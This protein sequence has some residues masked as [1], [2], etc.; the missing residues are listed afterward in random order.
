VSRRRYRVATI[1][2]PYQPFT[3]RDCPTLSWSPRIIERMKWKTHCVSKSLTK[4]QKSKWI[5]SVC[6]RQQTS[7]LTTRTVGNEYIEVASIKY[8]A[9]GIFLACYCS[10]AVA[11]DN[12]SHCS[13]ISAIDVKKVIVLLKQ[14]Q[15]SDVESKTRI[16]KNTH[17]VAKENTGAAPTGNA[18]TISWTWTNA[19]GYL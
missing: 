4:L 16:K 13:Q 17:V 3:Q 1:Y 6:M 19:A 12:A 9:S 14:S 5:G 8:L 2:L 15:N 10:A 18:D 11:E 7:N